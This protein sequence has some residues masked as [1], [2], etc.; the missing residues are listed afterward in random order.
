MEDVAQTAADTWFTKGS[1][2]GGGESGFEGE[3]LETKVLGKNGRRGLGW[4]IGMEKRVSF[5][6][7]GQEE[8]AEMVTVYVELNEGP[9]L[10]ERT[11]TQPQEIQLQEMTSHSQVTNYVQPTTHPSPT[12]SANNLPP[13]PTL[14]S[15]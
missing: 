1:F 12:M 15:I 2:W 13:D 10:G 11:E 3:R 4:V 9:H 6:N 5:E 8:E 14:A 7:Y